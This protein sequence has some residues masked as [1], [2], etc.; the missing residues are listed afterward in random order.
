MGEKW[1]PLDRKSVSTNQ[2]KRLI[3]KYFSTKRERTITGRN[4]WKIDKEYGFHYPENPFPLTVMQY[5]FNNTFPFDIKVKLSVAG[6]SEIGK[7]FP[8]AGISLFFEN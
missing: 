7:K 2:N 8:L 4:V 5:P 1:F 6:E 3:S